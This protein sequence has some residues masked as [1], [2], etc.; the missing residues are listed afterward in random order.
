VSADLGTEQT[1]V[2]TA[3]RARSPGSHAVEARV[4]RWEVRFRAAAIVTDLVAITIAVLIGV[5]LGLGTNIPEFGDV[6]PSVG[7]LAGVLMVCGLVATRAA[8][9]RTP[10]RGRIP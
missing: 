8:W 6:S 3:I 7:V 1:G 4:R 2:A 9:L 5:A 10:R